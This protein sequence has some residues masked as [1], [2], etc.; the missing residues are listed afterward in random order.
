[1]KKEIKHLNKT[2]ENKNELKIQSTKL[3]NDVKI[4]CEFDVFLG[5]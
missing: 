1:M 2:C 5:V 4:L 3:K